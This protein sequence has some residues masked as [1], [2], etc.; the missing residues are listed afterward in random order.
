MAAGRITF[1]GHATVLI[2]TGG[3]R[4]LT[5]PLL[6]SRLGFLRRRH[7]AIAHQDLAG[8]DAVL[9]SHMHFDHLDLPSLRI[10]GRETPIVAPGGVREFLGRVGFDRV[11]EVAAGETTR[12]REVEVTATPAA[13]EGR[14]HAFGAE[15]DAVGYLVSGGIRVYFA[16]DTDIFDEM[17]DIGPGVDV[18]LVPI[19]GWGPSLGPGHLDPREAAR[20]LALIGPRIAVP[21]HWG[22]FTPLGTGRIWP[23]ILTRPVREFLDHAKR[24]APGVEVRV[25]APG[26]A[27]EVDAAA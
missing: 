1:L 20:A 21:I 24:E 10:V 12:V 17:A 7:P 4:L 13:H 15:G 19:W 23:H 25:M 27:I 6:R 26:S 22:T 5:D 14:R 11:T 3:A 8:L 2:E 18:A 9:L 16:G